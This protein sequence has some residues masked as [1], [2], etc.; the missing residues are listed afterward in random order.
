[1]SPLKVL[2]RGYAIAKHT[3]GT[4]IKTAEDVKTGDRLIVRLK[5]DE[6]KCIA[7]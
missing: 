6:I 7:E 5:Q 3:D 2:G 1:M 4:I